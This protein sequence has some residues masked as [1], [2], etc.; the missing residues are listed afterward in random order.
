RKNTR[1]LDL[2]SGMVPS[3]GL[4]VFGDDLKSFNPIEVFRV[5]RHQRPVLCASRRCDPSII[6]RDGL[7]VA[8]GSDLAPVLSYLD[9]GLDHA[10]PSELV[11]QPDHLARTP[12]LA[13]CSFIEF[14][15]GHEGN[16][17]PLALQVPSV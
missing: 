14:G 3:L 15:H 16:S 6:H 12:S 17:Q 13:V 7:S 5:V 2:L 4:E 8:L 1:S 9:T 10:I 11:L